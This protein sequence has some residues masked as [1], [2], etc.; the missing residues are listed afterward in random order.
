LILAELEDFAHVLKMLHLHPNQSSYHT[1]LYQ[2]LI[3]VL[4]VLIDRRMQEVK[5]CRDCPLL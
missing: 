3:I 5:Y 4:V 1:V 2:E